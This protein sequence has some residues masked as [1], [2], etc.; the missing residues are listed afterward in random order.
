MT[1]IVAAVAEVAGESASFGASEV[2]QLLL[3]L[4]LVFFSGVLAAAETALTRVTKIRA[5]SLLEDGRRG[6]RAVVKIVDTPEKFISPL[7]LLVLFSHLTMSTIVGLLVEPIFGAWGVVV[8]IVLELVIIFIFSE[9]GPKNYALKNSDKVALSLAPFVLTLTSFP[10]IRLV[11]K[12]MIVIGNVLLPGRID[13]VPTTSEQELLAFTDAALDEDVIERGEREMIHS[14]VEFGDTVVREVMKP[15]TDMITV[16]HN[17]TIEEA[18]DLAISAGYSRIPVIRESKDDIAGVVYAKDLMRALRDGKREA[19]VA[20]IVR[21]AR[22]CPESKRVA[23]LM[24]EMQTQKFH[25]CVVLDEYGGTAGLCTLEDLIEELI[26]EIV[27]EYDVEEAQVQKLP[28]GDVLVNATMLIDELN[29]IIDVDWPAEDW[30]SV[31]GLL[32]NQLGHVAHEG[33]TVEYSHHLLRAERVKGRRIGRVRIT[34]LPD[35]EHDDDLDPS[36]ES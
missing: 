2:G 17:K 32:F 28:N 5:S 11:T 12:G 13:D 35:T 14:V 26:G 29:E 30:D 1:V 24:R 34:R 36:D 4:F 15:R 6:A 23:D 8:A 21:P 33:E 22:F 16:A 10:P 18:M 25:M 7:L 20:S 27:D 9:L 31:G 3:V 19:H